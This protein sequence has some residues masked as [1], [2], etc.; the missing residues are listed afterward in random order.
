MRECISYIN[1][2]KNG[3]E[4]C[5]RVLLELELRSLTLVKQQLESIDKMV[6]KAKRNHLKEPTAMRRSQFIIISFIAF[7]N[8]STCRT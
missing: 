7:T 8:N 1:T 4:E 3:G 6:Q 2:Q 5:L